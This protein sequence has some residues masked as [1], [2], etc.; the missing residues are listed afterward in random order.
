MNHDKKRE[1]RL[2]LDCSA[3][4]S[5]ISKELVKEMNLKPINKNLLILS[6]FGTTKPNNI[7]SP[8]VEL[9]TLLSNGFTINI[10]TNVVPN[11]TGSFEKKPINN[12]SIKKI[13]KV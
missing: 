8:V 11:V 6:T 1:N 2:L 3:Q 9:G 5:Y 7:G 4:R 13:A 10:N 12:K